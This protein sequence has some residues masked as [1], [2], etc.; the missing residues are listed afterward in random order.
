MRGHGRSWRLNL[1]TCLI[2]H[3]QHILQKEASLLDTLLTYSL[4]SYTCRRICLAPPNATIF[5]GMFLSSQR[6]N[7]H[8]NMTFGHFVPISRELCRTLGGIFCDKLTVVFVF[9]C[10]NPWQC[11][12]PRSKWTEHTSTESVT[13]IRNWNFVTPFQYKQ[14]RQ[15]ANYTNSATAA[16]RKILMQTFADRGVV[17]WAA[18]QFPTAVNLGF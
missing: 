18:R 10:P 6:S 17:A 4:S 3:S 8:P 15:Q 5:A 12:L 13:F 9:F 2:H 11:K 14:T 16:G 1:N 7:A